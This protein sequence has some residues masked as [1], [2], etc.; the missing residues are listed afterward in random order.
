MKGKL[1]LGFNVRFL[2][3]LVIFLNFSLA[4]KGEDRQTL[5]AEIGKEVQRLMD[6]GDIPGL[7]LVIVK[8]SEEVFMKGYG[9][10]DI[11]NKVPVT[12]A[13]VFELGSC[14]KAFTALA[15]LHCQQMGL[16]NLDDPVSKYLPWF[17]ARFKGKGYEITLRQFLN[18]TSGIPFRSISLIPETNAKDALQQTVKKLAGI[19]LDNIPG[20]R[21][22]YATINYDVIGAV[23][24]EVSR[25]SYEEYIQ[26]NILTPLG[27]NDTI[28]GVDKENPPENMAAG[29]KVG[30]FSLYRY[31]APVFRGN[32]PAGYILSNGKDMARWLK[33]Q[34]GLV[35]TE[36]TPLVQ[37][38]HQVDETM[39]LN[40]ATLSSYAFGWNVYLE[41]FK[42]IDHGGDNPNFT[43]FI[44]FNPLEKIGVAVLAN[45]RST[46]TTFIANTVMSYMSGEGFRGTGVLGDNFGKGSS[47]ISLMVGFFILAVLVF[48]MSI[49]VDI[50]KARR[51]FESLSLKKVA[52]LVMTLIL[53]I[54]FL[55]GIYLVPSTIVGV[56][57][58]TAIVFSPLSFKLAILSVLTAMGMCYI[59]LILSTLFPQKNKYLRSIPLLLV[60][61]L[62]A[63]GANAIVIFLITTSI[64]SRADLFYQLYNFVLAFFV[65][66]V[67]RKLLQTR[68]IKITFDII[69]DLRMNLLEKI[70]YTSY[71]RFEKIQRGR[72]FAT[73]NNDTGQISGSANILVQLVT[74]SVTTVGAF[75]YLATIAFW[76]TAI[77]LLVVSVIATLYSV[78][79]RRTQIYFEEARDTQNVYMGLLNGMI[80]GFKELSLQYNKKK[81]YK[82]EISENCDEFRK[83]S[84]TALI[85]FLNAFLIGESLLIIVL[86]SVGYGI[87][88]LFPEITPVTLMAFIMVLLY[89]IGPINAMLNSIPAI[90][91]LR[92]SWNRIQGFIKDVPANMDPKEIEALDH[93][94]PVSVEHVKAKGLMFTYDAQNESEKFTVG[95]M[96]FEA[97]KGEIVFII[98]GNGSGKTTVAKLLTGLYLPDEGSIEVDGKVMSNYQLGEY[99]SVVFGDY[100]L[101]ERLYNVDLSGKEQEIERYLKLLRLEEKVSLQDDSFST[102]ELSGGQRKRLALLQ[103]YLEDRP[104]Y[105]FDE[106]AADQDPG[107]RKFFYRELLQKMKERGKIVIA[108]THDDHYFDVADKIVKMDMGKVELLEEGEKYKA[109]VTI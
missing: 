17:H 102:I 15:A 100:H 13:T 90:V 27:L 52:R 83:K 104:I 5:Y 7:S 57:M 68:L 109:S 98:G 2:V 26:K 42:R 74:S 87:P 21:F 10:A 28:V 12:P 85:K 8:G 43:S 53:Y 80:D 73:L 105:L 16:I 95:S 81:E 9:F 35:E 32:T 47:V 37:E 51:K 61:S 84:S 1:F 36:L 19:E 33:I 20:S 48:I 24:E 31:D 58:K 55:I 60:L 30:I 97:Q 88:R 25:M 34:M 69:Y 65:Y 40:R 77:T 45:S 38:S 44:V 106:I 82:K 11:E 72:V 86:G 79:T 71:Q 22:E 49:F 67:G 91:R 78:V 108:I 56:S 107:F 50:I 4:A 14:S 3:F 76:A 66:I 99:Y 59:A 89:L 103:C 96:D 93:S 18:H 92:V 94:N 46:H 70:F 101:F 39:P 29:Y 75:L 41:R 6:E 62:M 64:F 54:P 23:I 63:G